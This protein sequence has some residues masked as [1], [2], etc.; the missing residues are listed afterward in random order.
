[1]LDQLPAFPLQ[2]KREVPKKSKS[3]V[4]LSGKL[5]HRVR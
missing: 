4:K 5:R 3:V 2:A 1:M